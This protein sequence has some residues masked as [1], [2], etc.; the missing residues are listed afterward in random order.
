MIKQAFV[1]VPMPPPEKLMVGGEWPIDMVKKGQTWGDQAGIANL[2]LEKQWQ[3]VDFEKMSR[4]SAPFSMMTPE[5]V[6]YYLPAF[7]IY[8]ITNPETANT[9]TLRMELSSSPFSYCTLEEVEKRYSLLTLPQREAVA[10]YLE[11]VREQPEYG[12]MYNE[13]EDP[14][15]CVTNYWH[16]NYLT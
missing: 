6:H 11:Y 14:I 10:Q 5:A 2:L 13:S 8:A 3:Q 16:D 15:D 1:G 12:T 4:E 7:L 9:E